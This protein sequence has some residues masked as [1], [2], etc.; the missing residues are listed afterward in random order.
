MSSFFVPED[1]DDETTKRRKI[2]VENDT[3]SDSELSNSSEGELEDIPFSKRPD[4]FTVEV[5]PTRQINKKRAQA[6]ARRQKQLS[7]HYMAM[8]SFM[9]H[10]KIRNNWMNQ[11]VVLKTLRKNV[12]SVVLKKVSKLTKKIKNSSKD[13]ETRHLLNYII[14]YLVKWFRHN[15]EIVSPGIRVL[16]YLPRNT[17]PEDIKDYYSHKN[18]PLAAVD[19]ARA[20]KS[21]KHNRDTGAQIFTALLRSLGFEARLVFSIPLLSVSTQAKYA[22]KIDYDKLKRINDSD[23]LYPY[24]WTELMD[25]IDYTKVFLIETMCFHDKDKRVIHLNRISKDLK[26]CFTPQFYPEQSALNDM[27]MSHVISIDRNGS[28]L[29]VSARYMTDI[30]YRW[31]NRLDLRTVLGRSEL[32]FQSLIRFF[33]KAHTYS[34]KENEELTTLRQLA[35]RNYEIP[36]S[37]AAMK[38]SPNFVTRD[39][40]RYNEGILP[41]AKSIGLVKLQLKDTA[42]QQSVYSRASVIVGR[43][44]QHWKHLG[45]AIKPEEVSEPMKSTKSLKSVKRFRQD[46]MPITNLY[47]L[48]QT[49]IYVPPEVVYNDG[50]LVLPRN[51]YGNIE[52]YKPWMIPKDTIW[53]KL[54][55]IETILI[56]HK[57]QA[58]TCPIQKKVSYVPVVVGFEYV[59]RNGQAVPVKQGV[60]VHTSQ[61]DDAKRIWLY[62]MRYF[63]QLSRN[64]KQA[65]AL[66]N[67][68]SIIGA[69]RI[70]SKLRDRYG[71]ASS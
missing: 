65:Q 27:Q 51:K 55:N 33:N 41:T 56:K 3:E 40:L 61:A 22:P 23:L 11:R 29:D 5:L 47:T 71:A 66:Q 58:F 8:A 15:Y 12:P 1:L 26:N 14:N 50:S 70:Q 10:A 13:D 52:I 31:F 45:R 46:D 67:W 30:S 32:L 4:S 28:M 20:C 36:T 24:F 18:K 38:R 59:T 57:K 44:E 6:I 60:L 53:L 48:A 16:G 42:A 34:I 37:F 21:F 39:T 7:I 69:L 17:S 2:D 43:S 68:K 19:F 35:F 54:L 9:L 64:Q 25:P 63:Q 49:T 62:G